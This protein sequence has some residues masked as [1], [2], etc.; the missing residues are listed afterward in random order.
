M[1]GNWKKEVVEVY[2]ETSF[3]E[4]V[5]YCCDE[6]IISPEKEKQTIEA[7]NSNEDFEHEI[8]INFFDDIEISEDEFQ[9]IVLQFE[10]D[11]KNEN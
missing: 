3:K 9:E 5:L 2:L 1:M 7:Y 8:I 4:C 11:Y 10:G 6:G